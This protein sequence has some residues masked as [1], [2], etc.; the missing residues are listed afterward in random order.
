MKP[1]T[2]NELQG[3]FS[4]IGLPE[5]LMVELQVTDFELPWDEATRANRE[6]FLEKGYI[7]FVDRRSAQART[8]LISP[9]RQRVKL[10]SSEAV[11]TKISG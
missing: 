8:Y 6:R 4:E 3:R 9:Q 2:A 1:L 11:E 5:P 10:E 7:L